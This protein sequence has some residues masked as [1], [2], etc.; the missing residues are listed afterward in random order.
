M[1]PKRIYLSPPL[2]EGN[3]RK[4]LLEALDSNWVAPTGPFVERLEETLKQYTGMPGVVAMNSGTSAIH[5]ALRLCG[6]GPGDEVICPT[7]SFIA[8]AGPVTYLGAKPLFVDCEPVTWNMDPVLLEKTL[9]ECK[10]RSNRVKAVIFAYCYG[11]PSNMVQI[12]SICDHFEV[13]LIEDAAEALGSTYN[14]KP[15]GTFG[16][17]GIYSF[18][19]NKIATG[20]VGGALLCNDPSL[21]IHARKL[22]SQAKE[23]TQH[24]EHHE[25]G[26]NYAMSNLAAA[27]ILGQFEQLEAKVNKRRSVFENYT[28]QFKTTSGVN[29]Q[30]EVDG[31]LSNR[32]LSAF[33]FNLQC[34]FNKDILMEKLAQSNIESRP[35]W[36]PLHTQKAFSYPF[37]KIFPV[38]EL[39]FRTG[40]CLP[41]GTAI[42]ILTYV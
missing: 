41:S 34:K 39:L 23:Q 29:W 7:F 36:K 35:L 40:L 13:P 22:A 16:T 28:Y 24:F 9:Q 4:Y 14:Y 2:L 1:D 5:I 21:A 32:W 11:M 19:G 38:S 33:T 3:E 17:F 20:S 12:K 25:V 15:A 18:N 30:M 26:Y 6:V 8:S 37:C 27:V 42:N 31:A 10:S